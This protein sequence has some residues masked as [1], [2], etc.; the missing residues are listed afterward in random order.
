M[1][2][3]LD[4]MALLEVARPGIERARLDAQ[5]LTLP[6]GHPVAPERQKELLSAIASSEPEFCAIIDEGKEAILRVLAG[7]HT[8]ESERLAMAAFG[9]IASIIDGQ[10]QAFGVLKGKRVLVSPSPSVRIYAG[11]AL[12]EVKAAIDAADTEA[13]YRS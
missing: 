7:D 11:R 9:R 4:E 5:K 12:L 6:G 13:G 3:T 2:L 10:A 8:Q 1:R